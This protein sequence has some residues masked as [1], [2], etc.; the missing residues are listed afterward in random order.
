VS[1]LAFYPDADE[2]ERDSSRIIFHFHHR[3]SVEE[4]DSP[5][6]LG[7]S[8]VVSGDTRIELR[9][10]DEKTHKSRI[11]LYFWFHTSFL[12]K[13]INARDDDDETPNETPLEGYGEVAHYSRQMRRRTKLDA[14]SR[15]GTDLD[16]QFVEFLKGG[17]DRGRYKGCPFK[18]AHRVCVRLYYNGQEKV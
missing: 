5:N 1:P 12:E 4:Q 10:M 18:K 11:L 6:I 8:V 14:S 16:G 13:S 7:N 2:L 9:G 17:V 15:Y 3:N